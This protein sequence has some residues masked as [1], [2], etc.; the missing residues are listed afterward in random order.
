MYNPLVSHEEHKGSSRNETSWLRQI[1]ALGYILFG[2]PEE[3][4][5]YVV[6]LLQEDPYKLHVREVRYLIKNQAFQEARDYL[7]DLAAEQVENRSEIKYFLAQCYLGQGLVGESRTAIQEA[8]EIDPERAEYWDLLADCFLEQGQWQDATECLDKSLRAAPTRAETVFRLGTIY[9]YHG[10]HLEALR[11]FQG[12][13]QLKPHNPV[14][15]EMKAETHLQLEQIEQACRSFERALRYSANIDVAARL[16]YCYIQL[17]QV[18]KGI[19]YYELV[20]KHEP[21][22]FDALCNLAAVYQNQERSLEA[23]TLLERAHSVHPN[24]S[25]LLNNLA[26]TLVH[27]GRTRKATEYYQAALRLAP[28]H[29]LIMYNMSVCLVRRGNWEEAVKILERLLDIDPEHAEAW[30]LLGNI[31]DQ[32]NQYDVATDCFNHSLKLA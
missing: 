18:K 2:K 8:L 24:D 32:L 14:Y 23:L 7:E 16:A 4:I 26:Y 20:L 13:C 29:P 27:L 11:C 17:N 3:G 19:K 31:Y 9:S 1:Q 15:W 25:I 30:A 22:H 6:Q 21:D 28:D 12:C 10:E 5:R